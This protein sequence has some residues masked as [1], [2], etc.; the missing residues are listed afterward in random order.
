M[1]GGR[2]LHAMITS[3]G[4]VRWTRLAVAYFLVVTA[5]LVWPLFPI[6]GNHVEPRVLGMPW[7]L[8]YVLGVVMMNAL[9]LLGLYVARVVDSREAVAP[10]ALDERPLPHEGAE[11][12]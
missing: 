4:G 1:C 10:E 5:A 7:S 11:D 2:R 6:L 12:S 3:M 8:C 9:V